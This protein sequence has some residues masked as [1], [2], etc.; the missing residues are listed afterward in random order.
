M[1]KNSFK[2]LEEI[3]FKEIS[4]RSDN[5]R[6]GIDSDIGMMK[7][8]ASVIELYFPKIVDLFVSLAGGSPGGPEDVKKNRN[9][10]PDL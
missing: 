4:M 7:Y 1:K 2:E 6:N 5:I 8:V 10:Y 9:K 3:E